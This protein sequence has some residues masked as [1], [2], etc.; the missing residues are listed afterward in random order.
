MAEV[1]EEKE[2]RQSFYATQ[3][4]IHFDSEAEI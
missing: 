4:V 3:N 2:K 1:K